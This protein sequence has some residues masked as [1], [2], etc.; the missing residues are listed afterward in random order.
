MNLALFIFVHL[1]QLAN[2]WIV[3]TIFPFNFTFLFNRLTRDET[4]YV[5]FGH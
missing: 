2:F 5:C 3:T 1:N 4:I